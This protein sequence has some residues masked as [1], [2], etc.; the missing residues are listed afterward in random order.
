M[1]NLSRT[2]NKRIDRIHERGLR[3]VYNDYLSSYD[4][5]LAKHGTVRIHHR[6]IQ[7]VA[8]EMFKVKNDLAPQ[9]MQCLFE[10]NRNA[11]P[12]QQTFIIPKVK[13]VYM[14]KL[15]LRYFGPVVWET[16]LPKEFKEIE[17]LHKFKEEIKKWVPNCKCRLCETWVQGVGKVDVAI[18][19]YK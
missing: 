5:L 15:S 3:I 7:L 1:F 11:K 16:M 10:I 6:N 12:G 14:G 19:I 18:P 4:E 13:S 8:V 9:L 2:L 17:T